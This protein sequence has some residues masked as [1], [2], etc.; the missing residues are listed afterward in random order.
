LEA[1]EDY[2][3]RN[4]HSGVQCGGQHIVVLTPPR[5]VTSPD[6]VL[7]DEADECPR[8]VVN[9]GRRRDGTSTGEYHRE[10]DVF[11]Y[12][13][14]V[15]PRNKV[16]DPRCDGT[17]EEKPSERVKDLPLGKLQPWSYDTPY[18]GSSTESSGTG[19]DEAV[20]LVRVTHI[21]DI[22]K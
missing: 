9:R 19:A 11:E 7:E 18:Y 17:Y 16:W 20:L 15:F 22:L 8:H 10:V 6:D 3:N 21:L 5:K 2:Y 13:V 12:G 14:G 4:G 1:E